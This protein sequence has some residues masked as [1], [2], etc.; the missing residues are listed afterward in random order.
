MPRPAPLASS[1]T[2]RH[3]PSPARLGLAALL[4]IS[5]LH[6]TAS[7]ARAYEDKITLGV[8]V[9]YAAVL[10]NPD[11]PT[12]GARLAVEVGI[13]L[14]DAWSLTPR[15][16]YVLHPATSALH[17]GLLG[18]EVTYAL[19]IV[20]VVPVFGLGLDAIGT[21]R[22]GSFGADI[23][24]HVVVGLDWLVSRTW[25][26]GLDVRAY[27]LPLSLAETGVDPVYLTAGLRVAFVFDRF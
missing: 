4:M 7:E 14:N 25:L 5:A 26:L 13:G 16:E 15:F 1:P 20:A 18:V 22:G 23:A 17:V 24:A 19:D 6:E 2:K 3:R 10:A 9:G 21:V 12:H 27:F 8:G 11:L